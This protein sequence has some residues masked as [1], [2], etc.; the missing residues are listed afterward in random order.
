MY[1][2][3][4]FTFYGPHYVE[5]YVIKNGVVVARDKILVPTKH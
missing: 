4:S 1:S 3:Y 2:K 5:C